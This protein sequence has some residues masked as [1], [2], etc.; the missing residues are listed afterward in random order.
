MITQKPKMWSKPLNSKNYVY[1]ALARYIGNEKTWNCFF[2]SVKNIE[3]YKKCITMLNN[4]NKKSIIQILEIILQILNEISF[5]YENEAITRLSFFNANN[6][7]FSN[8]KT[9]LEYKG[10]LF[11]Q[12]IPEAEIKEIPFNTRLADQLFL[13]K[14]H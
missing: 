12:N 14:K 9:L 13:L 10:L 1:Y 2:K 5:Y 11:N 7:D 6:E 3:K 8:I 4:N